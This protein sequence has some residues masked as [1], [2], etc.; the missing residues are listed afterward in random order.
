ME[1]HVEGKKLTMRLLTPLESL[2]GY[3]QGLLKALFF[4]GRKE[5]DT[6][7]IRAH[8]RSS[9][10]DPVEKVRAGL[11]AKLKT[12]PDFQDASD[13]PPRWPTA[14]LVGGALLALALSVMFSG[15]EVGTVIG[16]LIV[17]AILWGLGTLCAYTYQKRIRHLGAH[18][19]VFLWVPVV[20]LY[21]AWSG[22]REN[23]RSSL[24]LVVGV[25][26][27]RLAIVSNVFHLASTRNG[28]KRMARRKALA[29]ARAFFARELARPAPRL[30]DG[31]F[32]YVVAFGLTGD[33]DRWFRAHGARA[34]S[35]GSGSSPA[36]GSTSTGSSGT[37]TGGGGAFGGAGA[38]GSW[39]LAAGALAAGV[40]SPSSSSGSGG[41][42]GGG[43][44]GSSG[45]G[46]GGGW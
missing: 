38:S 21:F 27:L 20:I 19:L 33:A 41:G 44:G 42:S 37:W 12:H 32:P 3:D 8:Y 35:G 25:Y 13:P 7:A 29:S 22:T 31:W 14:L 39:A 24:L 10:F 23:A 5:T 34:T 28:A 30:Q 26:L 36:T 15:E 1:T 16:I 43:G 9:G 6:D 46:G 17:H 2:S 4:G 45:G 11:E 18:A 40:A